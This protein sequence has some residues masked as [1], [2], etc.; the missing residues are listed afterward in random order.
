MDDGLSIHSIPF[1]ALTLLQLSQTKKESLGNLAHTLAA[2]IKQRQANQENQA[3][4]SN[5]QAA[6]SSTPTPLPLE[7]G[8]GTGTCPDDGRLLLPNEIENPATRQ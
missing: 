6:S 3:T 1:P 2:T 7:S 5:F 4:S 8:A